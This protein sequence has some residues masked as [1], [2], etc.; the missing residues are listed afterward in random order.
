MIKLLKNFKKI[1]F[2]YLLIVIGLIVFQVYLDLKLPDYMS[3]ITVLVKTEGSKISDI[4]SEGSKMLLCAGGSLLSAIIVCYFTSLISA[5]YS[6]NLR[7]KLFM[8]VESFGME[9]MKKFSTGSLITRT[10]NDITN[11]QMFISMGMQMLIK[12]PIT[13]VWAIIKIL[14]KNLTWSV[15]TGGFVIAMLVVIGTLMSIV[16]S[17]FKIIQNY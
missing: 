12:A 1:D 5:R 17:K 14:N 2:F 4:L 6:R 16:L 8:N 9:E 15:M 3:N 13:A 10:T 11:V 7:K